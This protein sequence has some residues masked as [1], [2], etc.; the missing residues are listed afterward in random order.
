M[1]VRELQAGVQNSAGQAIPLQVVSHQR[2]W[3]FSD[4]AQVQQGVIQRVS[5]QLAWHGERRCRCKQLMQQ[6]P[7]LQNDLQ[8]VILRT[9]RQ[10]HRLM[11]TA[12][13]NTLS[14]NSR[15]CKVPSMTVLEERMDLFRQSLHC[16]MVPSHVVPPTIPPQWQSH[17]VP[18]PVGGPTATHH[19][20]SVSAYSPSPSPSPSQHDRPTQSL[21]H[22][23]DLTH[24]IDWVRPTCAADISSQVSTTPAL[25]GEHVEGLSTLLWGLCLR[26]GV[27]DKQLHRRFGAYRVLERQGRTLFPG[28]GSLC[29]LGCGRFEG[30]CT[31]GGS[32]RY[33]GH[34]TC[35]RH[36]ED[37]YSA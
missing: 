6:H 4:C 25:R 21:L 19:G 28:R 33:I 29:A 10:W 37:G 7:E 11:G 22:E 20:R 15:Q 3:Q 8:H 17:S 12:G 23:S 14:G 2:A 16:M 31:C 18:S 36:C 24:I 32:L 30:S 27:W 5:Q 13:A 26:G 34:G 9:H 1:V 35:T